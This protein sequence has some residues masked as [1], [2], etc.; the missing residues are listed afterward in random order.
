MK[1]SLNNYRNMGAGELEK[2][3]EDLRES[4]RDI[5][6]KGQGA[7]PKNVKEAGNIKRDIARILTVLVEKK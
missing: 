1:K 6:F 7:K 3:L 2:K 5:R 4:V